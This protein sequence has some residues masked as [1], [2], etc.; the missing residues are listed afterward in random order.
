MERLLYSF[1]KLDG[2]ISEVNSDSFIYLLRINTTDIDLLKQLFELNFIEEM[3]SGNG[4]IIMI[5]NLSDYLSQSIFIE[6]VTSELKKIAFYLSLKEFVIDNRFEIPDEFYI[7]ELKYQN[8]TGYINENVE[9]Y[10]AVTTLIDR[11]TMKSKFIS[12]SHD[13]TLCLVQENSF[14]EMPIENIVYEEFLEKE[15]ISLI[16]QYINDIDSYKE[17]STIYFKELI[18]FLSIQNK[19]KRLKTLISFFGDFY[20]R[21]NISFEYYLSDFSFNKIKL[22]LDNSVLEY[23]RNIRAII[24]ESQSKLIAIP[25][26]FILGVSQIMYSEPLSLK[27]ILI[28]ASS[29][30]FSYIIFV[31]IK[32]QQNA[33]QIV[34]DNLKNYKTN[35]KRSKL[36]QLEEEKDLVSLSVLINKSF[37]KTEL[38]LAEQKKRLDKIQK[39]NWGISIVLLISI[40]WVKYSLEI[41]E[42]GLK[43]INIFH[44]S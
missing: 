39:C 29:F 17:K 1:L 38:E 19:E 10:K 6:F 2:K 23:S 9:K 14:M 7:L 42:L 3:K 28:I 31:F 27:N 41:K 36:T 15:N 44:N 40:I 34:A 33:L 20:E 21:C 30:L 4:K 43:I 16:K 25:A 37:S 5:D 8:S 12:D 22:E 35:Y 24:N 32:N 13:R 26:A 11:L 18:C